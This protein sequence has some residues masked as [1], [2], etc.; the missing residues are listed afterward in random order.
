MLSPYESL[1]ESTHSS[2]SEKRITVVTI[3]IAF[4][5]TIHRIV[6]EE[7][8]ISAIPSPSRQG[9]P[10]G[11][12]KA[13]FIQTIITGHQPHLNV[14]PLRIICRK[15]I[16]I[17]PN[18]T[19]SVSIPPTGSMGIH[20]YCHHIHIIEQAILENRLKSMTPSL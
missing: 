20:R 12:K 16:C 17:V 6:R 13:E 9:H 18:P 5:Q 1:S 2:N 4:H 11:T 19:S 7:I 14:G 15:G 10:V 8:Q 3:T